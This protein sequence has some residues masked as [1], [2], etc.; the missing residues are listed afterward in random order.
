MNRMTSSER[1]AE[2]MRRAMRH[3][4]S[5]GK[6]E[7]VLEA[8]APTPHPLTVAINREAG[9]GGPEVARVVGERLGWAVYD[10]ELVEHIAGEMGLRTELVE[11]VDEKRGNWLAE[12]LQG[13]LSQPGVSEARYVQNLVQ[14]LFS[15][16]AHG[17]CVIVGRGAAHVLPEET[18]LRVR[19]I[20]P[21]E[22]RIE[23]VQKERSLS[24]E[25]A[26]RWVE[27]TDRERRN[28]ARAHFQK[29]PDDPEYYDLV[30]NS[31]RLG[32]EGCVE[33]I[34]AAL[35]RLRAPARS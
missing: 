26:A 25:E 22:K 2:A 19:L 18:T 16:A 12:C 1:M 35:Q 15:L 32:V 4:Q 17:E 13:F 14:T 11:S 30:L 31:S 5:R 8:P 28:F 34:L 27:N 6:S 9:T 7:P 3:W 23:A 10:R 24:H 29:D 33:L 21:L 20:G